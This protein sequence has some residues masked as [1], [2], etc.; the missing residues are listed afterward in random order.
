MCDGIYDCTDNSDEANQ[1]CEVCDQPKR[2][3]NPALD[4]PI[5]EVSD[6]FLSIVT[7]GIAAC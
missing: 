7:N 5:L 2:K 1:Y 3:Q 4:L 6:K